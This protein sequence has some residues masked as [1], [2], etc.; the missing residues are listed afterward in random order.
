MSRSKKKQKCNKY[1][2][3]EQA[4]DHLT[5]VD[6]SFERALPK[7]VPRNRNQDEL[8]G[9]LED[10]S[11]NVVFAVGPAGT[12]KTMLSTLAGITAMKQ[13]KINKFVVTRPAVCVD[14]DHGF[15]PGDLNQKMAP[16]MLPIFDVFE[17]HWS[18][19]TIEY[20]MESHKIE[21]APLAYMRGRTFKDSYIILDEAQNTT[22]EQMKMMLTR[23]GEGSKLIVTGDIQQH[24]RGYEENGLLDFVQRLAATRS[25]RIKVVEF[26]RHDVERHPVV[27]EVLGIYDD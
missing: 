9:F 22:P 1:R 21:I 7:V 2:N 18:T 24:D 13:R 3:Q 14:E 6:T 8:L 19:N 17:E 4:R 5:V 25:D 27:K 15:L 26:S 23:I 16:W 10:D 12:G 11:V 20:M